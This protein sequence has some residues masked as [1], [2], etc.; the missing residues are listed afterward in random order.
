[1]S[2]RTGRGS[3]G[4]RSR[5]D[6]W[7]EIAEAVGTD[8]GRLL[9]V[10]QVHGADVLVHRAGRP[11]ASDAAADII[12]GDDASMALAI[13]T[14]D[15]VPLLI[16][17]RRTGAVAAAH[18]G[19]RGTALRV[20]AAA[21]NAMTTEFGSRPSD[22]VAAVGPSIGPCCYQVGVDV[23]E[24]FAHEGFHDAELAR[25]FS[26]DAAAPAGQPTDGPIDRSG[27]A[28]RAVPESLDGD[29]RSVG[30]GRCSARPDLRR[31]AV[32]GKPRARR[33]AHTVVTERMPGGLRRS[34]GS[35]SLNVE[36]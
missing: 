18:A 27:D 3:S 19:W 5:P 4:R 20:A 2:L 35:A 13:Q 33:S 34:S 26:T 10:R 29:A 24:R 31:G 7:R 32:H 14:A 28:G 22:L 12:V 36:V 21:V 8:P 16:G 17:D 25:W 6:A 9:R 23:R 1:M 11:P 15:C 30:G